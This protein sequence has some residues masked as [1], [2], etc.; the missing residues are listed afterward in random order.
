MIMRSIIYF[1]SL[2]AIAAG[3]L[4]AQGTVWQPGPGHSQVP[5]WPGAVP[6]AVPG[7]GS[8]VNIT[9]SKDRPVGG[10]PVFRIG[11]VTEP[12][13]TYYAPK[14]NNTGVGLVVFPGGGYGHLSIDIEGTEVCDWANSIGITCVVLKYRVPASGPYPK[15]PAALEDAQR[16][17]SLVRSQAAKWGIDPHRIGVVGFSAGAHLG[18]ALS[19]HFE[20]RLYQPVDAADQ[21]SCRPDF[22]LIIYPGY[23]ALAEQNFAP[24]PDIHVTGNT[25]PAFLVQT[26]DDR[27]AHVESSIA[28]YLALKNANVP[29]EMHLYAEGVH[30]YGLRRT[31]FAVAEWPRLAETWL[32]TIKMLPK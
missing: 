24:N 25:P 8:D 26:E 18:A 3:S 29:V 17:L 31:G 14:S 27:A 30:G 6:D 15:S 11:N 4:A 16:A 32:H 23:L 1:V 21:A 13:I 9:T 5:I 28:Y 10:R 22:A 7:T 12:T 2:A 20:Q 19:T